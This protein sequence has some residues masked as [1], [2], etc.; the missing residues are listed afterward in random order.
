M[1]ARDGGKLAAAANK[2]FNF[3]EWEEKVWTVK[4]K[5]ELCF[6]IFFI[7][8]DSLFV[9]FTLLHY[10]E[11][12]F[13][14]EDEAKLLGSSLCVCQNLNGNVCVSFRTWVWFMFRY[15]YTSNYTCYHYQHSYLNSEAEGFATLRD[16]QGIVNDRIEPQRRKN[17]YFLVCANT[18]LRAWFNLAL[19][20]YAVL[21][22]KRL[23]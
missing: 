13:L 18:L 5:A 22:V 2:L 21:I 12:K 19:S 4:S 17:L 8:E 20:Y 15:N 14:S 11:S 16:N 10:A 1:S 6:V 7:I 23:F 9:A 3:S